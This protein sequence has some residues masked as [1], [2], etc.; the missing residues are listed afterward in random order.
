M[1]STSPKAKRIEYRC[2]DPSCNPYLAFTA[3]LMAGLDGVINRIDPGEPLDKDIY[4][5]E[6]EELKNVPSTPGSLDEALKALEEDHDYLLKGNVFT[7]DVINAWINYKA[8]KE[9]KQM[10]LRPHPFE[11]QLYFDV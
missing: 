4:D 3:I 7:E 11:Y 6:P 10:A 9:A 8:T 2:P 1:Y 5:M